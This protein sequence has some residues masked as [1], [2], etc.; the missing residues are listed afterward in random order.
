MGRVCEL[1]ARLEADEQIRRQLRWVA[2]PA[3]AEQDGLLANSDRRPSPP[4]SGVSVRATPAALAVLAQA[5]VAR[6]LPG[7]GRQRPA[8]G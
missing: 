5:D 4:R 7:P 2:N 1:V 6:V 8:P 3:A